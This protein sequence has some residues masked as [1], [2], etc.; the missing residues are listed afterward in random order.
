MKRLELNKKEKI[1]VVISV[2]VVGLFL[3]SAYNYY[4]LPTDSHPPSAFPSIGFETNITDEGYIEYNVS[5]LQTHPKRSNESMYGEEHYDYIIYNSSKSKFTEPYLRG[6]LTSIRNITEG[7]IIWED[8]DGDH[9]ISLSDIFI[10]DL[11]EIPKDIDRF[12]LYYPDERLVVSEEH[13][14]ELSDNLSGMLD[15]TPNSLGYAFDKGYEEC[16]NNNV[17]GVADGTSTPQINNKYLAE[18]TY[19]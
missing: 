19:I 6:S 13:I 15:Y 2:I 5:S 11:E 4:R 7:P 1:I 12:A 10:I 8:N 16:Q 17:W 14:K 18:K 9:K 3:L